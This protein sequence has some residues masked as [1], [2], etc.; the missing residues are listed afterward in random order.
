MPVLT[1]SP[2][3]GAHSPV[4]VLAGTASAQIGPTMQM[5]SRPKEQR[6]AV[7]NLVHLVLVRDMGT[8]NP[9]RFKDWI[10][11]TDA[12]FRKVGLTLIFD[13]RLRTVHFTIKEVRSS[14]TA[15]KFSASTRV[16]FDDRDVVMSVDDFA[17]P[18]R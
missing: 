18:M 2:A 16:Q 14:R 7:R 4:T 8:F 12:R 6:E 3:P 9:E 15:F 10:K 17:K 11:D 1:V 5:H 13:I